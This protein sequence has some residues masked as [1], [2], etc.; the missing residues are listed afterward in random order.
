[1]KVPYGYEKDDYGD[2]S[3]NEE[4]AAVVRWI[5]KSYNTGLSLG[6]IADLLAD[7]QVPSPTGNPRWTRASIDKLLSNPKYMPIV[8]VECYFDVQFEKQIAPT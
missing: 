3:I 7:H 2:I 5:F 4:K 8:G 1:M 6:K